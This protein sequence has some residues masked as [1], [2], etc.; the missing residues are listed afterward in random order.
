MA[1]SGKGSTDCQAT[2]SQRDFAIPAW[3]DGAQA[4]LPPFGWGDQPYQALP[5][6]GWLFSCASH[7]REHR[8]LGTVS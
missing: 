3:E 5:A 7:P 2:P 6:M 4:L 8:E 1:P